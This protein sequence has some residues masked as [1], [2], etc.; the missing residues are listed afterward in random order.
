MI[1]NEKV[2]PDNKNFFCNDAM[3]F[4]NKSSH[5]PQTGKHTEFS[6]F[7]EGIR[8]FFFFPFESFTFKAMSKTRKPS[9]WLIGNLS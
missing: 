1:R 6:V 9:K 7:P 8:I 2:R 3:G 5:L 4:L